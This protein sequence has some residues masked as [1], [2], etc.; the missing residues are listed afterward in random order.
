MF[1][2]ESQIHRY[3]LHMVFEYAERHK[4]RPL[5]AWK[6]FEQNGVLWFLT[7][8]YDIQHTLS[9]DQTIENIDSFISMNGS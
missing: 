3:I 1:A 2:T 7:E 6:K 9:M 8:H 4:I 5:D